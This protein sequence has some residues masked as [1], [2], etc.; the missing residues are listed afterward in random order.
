MT[1]DPTTPETG[2]EPTVIAVRGAA[3]YDVVVG[4]GVLDRLG[5]L[6]TGAVRVA[7]VVPEPLEAFI[8][9]LQSQ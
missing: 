8:A 6:V 9:R 1:T 3:P 4:H 7:I 2:A 5:P